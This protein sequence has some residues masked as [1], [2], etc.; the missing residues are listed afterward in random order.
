MTATISYVHILIALVLFCARFAQGR[1]NAHVCIIGAGISGASAA[2]FLRTYSSDLKISVFEKTSRP[3]GRIASLKLSNDSYIE[4]GASI[5]AADNMLMAYFV[6]FLN[7]TRNENNGDSE[8]LGLWDGN[9]FVFRSHPFRFITMLSLLRRYH[10]S[11]FR[12]K[13]F[14]GR[15]LKLFSKL[16]P[17]G[18][19]GELWTPY[20]SVEELLARASPLFETTQRRFADVINDKF[21]SV[22]VDE[23][24][25]AIVRVNYGQDVDAISGMAGSVGLAGSGGGL[26]SVAGGNEQVVAGLLKTAN[27]RM[28]LETAISR[29][30]KLDDG[31]VVASKASKRFCDAVIMAVPVE[32]ANIELPQALS[33]RMNIKR[34]FQTTVATFVRGKL[35]DKTFGSK[36]PDAIL[37]TSNVQDTFTSVARKRG[38]GN[39]HVFKV[40]SREPLDDNAIA[41]LFSSGA[42]ILA[43][44]P[45]LAY[46]KYTTP[47]RFAM[48]DI[49]ENGAFIYTSPLESAGSAMEMSA[50]AGAN[51]AALLREKLQL[52]ANGV[53][54][55]KE[56][57]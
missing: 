49:E 23:M 4:A 33:S 52:K 13:W 14:V 22:F 2:H 44:Y 5:I 31:Y 3:G 9:S 57:L 20:K 11:V 24:V 32:L 40:F 45:W 42:K 51:A 12:M 46:P 30:E 47:E 54:Q 43:Q 38:T 39:E 28:E 26:W 8:I 55:A 17:E 16:Y 37:T 7:L 18:G 53:A 25:A 41:R 15:L 29:V 35:N 36:P 21:S 1:P 27:V 56:E 6:N 19:P 10:L 50:I 34:T 48:F